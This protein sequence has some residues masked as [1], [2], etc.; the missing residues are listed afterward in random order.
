MKIETR[1][2]KCFDPSFVDFQRIVFDAFVQEQSW[3]IPSTDARVN[4]TICDAES[5]FLGLYINK[6]LV[7]GL[8][9]THFFSS[10]NPYASYFEKCILLD[11]PTMRPV[12]MTRLCMDKKFRGLRPGVLQGKSL[13]RVLFESADRAS[14]ALGF[15][16]I[17]LST[18]KETALDFIRKDAAY[19]SLPGG[20]RVHQD[21]ELFHL[22]KVLTGVGEQK[23]IK[24]RRVVGV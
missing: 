2:F 10:H 24:P 21:W 14:L 9:L 19:R 15:N 4:E 5:S 23:S 8:R 6:Q 3:A 12:L 18:C 11:D 20:G 1:I 7:G 16:V 22:A 13:A 17:L